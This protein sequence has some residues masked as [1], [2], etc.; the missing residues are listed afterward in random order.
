MGEGRDADIT[1][2]TSA[3][4]ERL[5][6]SA[7]HAQRRGWGSSLATGIDFQKQGI[8]NNSEVLLQG[9]AAVAPSKD[10]RRITKCL[11]SSEMG[12]LRLPL[13]TFCILSLIFTI[14]QGRHHCPHLQL[15]NLEVKECHSPPCKNPATRWQGARFTNECFD[16][17]IQPNCSHQHLGA[18]KHPNIYPDYI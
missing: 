12:R 10:F 7:S 4:T 3:W 13:S 16:F 14:L 18:V 11:G 5:L 9:Q 2:I 15:R 6:S 1:V 17:D 8:G